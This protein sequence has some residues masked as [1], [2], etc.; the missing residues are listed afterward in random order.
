MALKAHQLHRHSKCE[1]MNQYG[2][3]V[4]RFVRARPRNWSIILSY[5]A[6]NGRVSKPSL[7]SIRDP[8]SLAFTKIALA[9]LMTAL[10]RP[11]ASSVFPLWGRDL[12][13]ASEYR[14]TLMG[15]LPSAK[16]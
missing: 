8:T 10:R 14:L 4:Y 9:F 13:I 15:L 16:P 12:P 1:L 5:G 7:E 2:E 11:V 3:M 6:A